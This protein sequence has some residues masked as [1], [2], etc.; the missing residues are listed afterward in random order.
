MKPEPEAGHLDA[1]VPHGDRVGHSGRAHEPPP[2]QS[3]TVLRQRVCH[4]IAEKERGG[5]VLH[6]PRREQERSGAVEAQ[7]EAREVSG[8]LCEQACRP[9]ADVTK[10][11]AKTERRAFEDRQHR[12]DGT[13]ARNT[14]RSPHG[15]VDDRGEVTDARTLGRADS[16]NHPTRPVSRCHPHCR[17]SKQHRPTTSISRPHSIGSKRN[18]PPR[19]PASLEPAFHLSPLEPHIAAQPHDGITRPG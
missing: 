4:G 14:S 19:S 6:L 10:V 17:R 7:L 16:R 1:H 9:L 15:V 18:R 3:D 2:I 13:K 11:I 8:V 5:E 12:M